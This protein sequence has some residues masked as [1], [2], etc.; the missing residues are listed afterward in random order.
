ME[1]LTTF[2][3]K[4]EIGYYNMFTAHGLYTNQRLQCTFGHL[5]YENIRDCPLVLS[6]V[7]ND[8]PQHR[9]GRELVAVKK[10]LILFLFFRGGG[11]F[12]VNNPICSVTTRR[13]IFTL[14]FYSDLD[15][16]PFSSPAHICLLLNPIVLFFFLLPFRIFCVEM[17]SP[18]PSE[19]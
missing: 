16:F 6:P 19:F 10:S 18:I 13:C 17:W 15:R 8:T 3:K 1:R 7:R 12:G 11:D 9:M 2:Q 4:N 5:I 14:C